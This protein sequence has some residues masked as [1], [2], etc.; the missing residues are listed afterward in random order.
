M[1]V[2]HPCP[3]DDVAEDR[4]DLVCVKHPFLLLQ[5][6]H[7]IESF[8][9]FVHHLRTPINHFHLANRRTGCLQLVQHQLALPVR[10]IIGYESVHTNILRTRLKA[11]LNC[12]FVQTKLISDIESCRLLLFKSG[13]DL[14]KLYLPFLIELESTV[15]DYIIKVLFLEENGG[16][17]G[18][19]VI[20]VGNKRVMR[21]LSL[22]EGVYVVVV[23]DCLLENLDDLVD[24]INQLAHPANSTCAVCKVTDNIVNESLLYLSQHASRIAQMFLQNH[25]KFEEDL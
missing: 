19:D 13:Y 16:S 20:F 9:L 12:L 22:C 23:N 7:F 18:E 5:A 11:G 8:D 14:L 15:I 4:K 24:A 10:F 6:V 21:K 2:L 3:H 1:Q 25:R 17:D